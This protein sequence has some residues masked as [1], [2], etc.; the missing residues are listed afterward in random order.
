MV[1]TTQTT[2]FSDAMHSEKPG[3]LDAIFHTHK[4]KIPQ[5]DV[6]FFFSPNLEAVCQHLSFFN[7]TIFG[8]NASHGIQ[9][10]HSPLERE[11]GIS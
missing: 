11:F 6:G 8:L 1:R 7:Y 10:Q 9:S 4:K 5:A 2:T 3:H